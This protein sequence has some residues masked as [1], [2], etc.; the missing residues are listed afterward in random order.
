MK[1]I[2]LPLILLILTTIACSLGEEP[3]DYIP[4]EQEHVTASSTKKSPP[5][6]PVGDQWD[7]WVGGTRLR[8]ANIHSCK[9]LAENECIEPITLRDVQDLRD[10]GA[11]VINASYPGVFKVTPPYELN[12]TAL[13]YLD[14]LVM[15]AEE[16]DIYLVINFRSG[17]GR[18]EEAIHLEA[19]ANFDVWEDQ[20][21]HDAW[22]EMWRFTAE[23]YKDNPV[24]IGYNLLT[25]PHPNTLVDP[26]Y[27]MSPLEVQAEIEGTLKDWNTFAAEITSAIRE[28]DA[29]TPIIIDSLGW[30]A[31]HFFQ[32]L[33]PT[34]DPYTIYSVHMY[35][36]DI[37]SHQ[38]ADSIEIGYPDVV[39]HYGERI[40]FNRSWLEDDLKPV[41]EFAEEHE[42]PVFVGEYGPMRWVPSGEQY[43]SDLMSIF[44]QHGWHY[45]YYVWRGDE[46]YFDGFN[47]EYGS[48]PD[49]HAPDKDNP[50]FRVLLHR[51]ESNIDFPSASETTKTK[52]PSLEEVT[53]WI[54]FIDVNLESDVIDQIIDSNY[55]MVV[56]DFIPSEENNVDYPIAEVIDQ[57]HN[58]EHPKLMIA[59]IDIGEAEEFRTY[60]QPGWRI[61]DPEWIIA[62]D[63]DGWEGN[64]P[65]AFWWDEYRYIWLGEDGYLQGILDAGFDGVYLDW[66]EAYS[67]ENVIAFADEEDT[68]PVEEMIRW[69]TDIAEFTRVQDSDFIVIAQN[70]AELAENDEYLATIDAIAQEQVWFDGGADNDP[71]GDCPLPRTEAEVDT[72]A[73]RASLS[74]VCHKQYDEYPESTL[75][76]SS[77]E[78]LYF[79]SM[80][81]SKGALIFTV[82]YALDP[83]N[84]D[85]VYR[86]SRGLGFVPFVSN[87]QLDQYVEPV[88]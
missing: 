66:V 22:I 58:A 75:H 11:N 4:T 47:M 14:D 87:R 78:Y 80:A 44:E 35:D 82:D 73:Y 69:V 29:E 5:T 41:I 62:L 86:T 38:E 84:I 32:A 40:D 28:V 77:E 39:N 30:A 13:K 26:D 6:T 83:A 60:W 54:Y 18:N 43:L 49:N 7:L 51:W 37:Y 59:Y 48:D 10:L 17:P 76:V 15:W 2:I 1:R 79:L 53:N 33:Q 45:A 36:P 16:A 65:V 34:G 12:Q 50:L 63:P 57:M 46:E 21:A 20:E 24:V 72:E 88:P 71:P 61:G 68:D 9:L 74:P 27:E 67:D 52:F 42:V 55:D 81:Q 56:I 31:A 3:S 25:E 23:R 70:A 85:W 8:G 19:G 64:Y